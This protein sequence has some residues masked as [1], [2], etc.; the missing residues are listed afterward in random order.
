MLIVSAQKTRLDPPFQRGSFMKHPCYDKEN[1]KSQQAWLLDI[2]AV[3]HWPP[4]ST[5]RRKLQHTQ[6]LSKNPSN[7]VRQRVC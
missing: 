5:D 6:R 7:Q 4:E 3:W 1:C 2:I